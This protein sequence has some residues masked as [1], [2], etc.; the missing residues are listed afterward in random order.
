MVFLKVSWAL[1]VAHELV[2]QLHL[3]VEIHG[4]ESGIRFMND[5]HYGEMGKLS[6][7]SIHLNQTFRYTGNNWRNRRE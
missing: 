4:P 7:E 6:Q 3:K 5:L 1:W 2:E